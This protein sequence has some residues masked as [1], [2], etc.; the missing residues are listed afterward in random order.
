MSQYETVFGA[1]D[2]FKTGGVIAIDD[3]PKN[4]VFSNVYEVAAKS[5][6]WE[7]VAV[8]KNFEYV[9]EAMRAEG[10]S[11]WYSCAHD[12]FALNMDDREVTVELLKLDDPDSLVDQESEGGHKLAG[13]PAGRKMGWV[14]LRRGHMAL[15]PVGSAY[16]FV[17]EAPACVLIQTIQGPETIERWADICQSVPMS[18]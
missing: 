15:L 7:R 1:I 5:A 14:K 18:A 4:Y 3:D 2:D 8:G 9:I 12:E 16:R 17:A 11:A 6:P 10:T 13:E